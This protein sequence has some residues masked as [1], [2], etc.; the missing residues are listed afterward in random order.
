VLAAVTVD[1]PE[2]T[3]AEAPVVIVTQGKKRTQ[4]R[5]HEGKLYRST[6]FAAHDLGVDFDKWLTRHG[7]AHKS[8]HDYAMEAYLAHDRSSFSLWPRTTW[9]LSDRTSLERFLRDHMWSHSV[10][11]LTTRIADMEEAEI[12]AGADA[13]RAIL[14]NYLVVDGTL[15]ERAF[16]PCLRVS[17]QKGFISLEIDHH[18]RYSTYVDVPVLMEGMRGQPEVGLGL[19]LFGADRPDE[20]LDFANEIS[21]RHGPA[22]ILAGHE[23]IEVVDP[24]YVTGDIGELETLRFAKQAVFSARTA[25][26]QGVYATPA[27][28]FDSDADPSILQDLSRLAD[29]IRD[30]VVARETQGGALASVEHAFLAMHAYRKDLR[31][32]EFAAVFGYPG[33]SLQSS[34]EDFVLRLGGLSI[35]LPRFG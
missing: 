14:D 33:K 20:A 30:A 27:Q 24:A 32:S 2:V 22:K 11:R 8:A 23:T 25:P 5:G 6:R 17:V 28:K 12:G 21:P 34:E 7:G 1:I 31:A 35:P 16:E 9:D 15:W 26:R 3:K 4:L 18:G 29:D 10:D 19:H 13:A